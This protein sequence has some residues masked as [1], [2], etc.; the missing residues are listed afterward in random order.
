MKK[1]KDSNLVAKVVT[2]YVI[3]SLD[4]QEVKIIQ[5]KEDENNWI[6]ELLYN[7][8]KGSS[9]AKKIKV[10]LNKENGTIGKVKEIS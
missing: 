4:A 2:N 1:N 8:K 9:K 3:R 10:E 7:E 6:V 5:I